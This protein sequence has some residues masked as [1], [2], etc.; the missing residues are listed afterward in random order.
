MR[1]F[2][3]AVAAF[4]ALFFNLA[5][6]DIAAAQQ[7]AE[8][9]IAIPNRSPGRLACRNMQ[10]LEEAIAALPTAQSAERNSDGLKGEGCFWVAGTGLLPVSGPIG[11]RYAG[12]YL[13]LVTVVNLA[14]GTGLL[15]PAVIADKRKWRL[16]DECA[17]LD[18]F[19]SARILATGEKHMFFGQRRK[20]FDPFCV[21]L[22][23][24]VA[25]ADA[26][27]QPQQYLSDNWQTRSYWRNMI[28]CQD[29]GGL[30]QSLD[31]MV[32]EQQINNSDSAT[33]TMKN[34]CIFRA[35]DEIVASRFL[36]LYTTMPV[37]AKGPQ[38]VV[39][40]HEVVHINRRTGVLTTA[41]MPTTP[42]RARMLR[43]PAECASPMPI[44]V[45]GRRVVYLSGAEQGS[46]EAAVVDTP[47]GRKVAYSDLPEVIGVQSCTKQD[48]VFQR[49]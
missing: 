24:R 11:W 23:D 33:F 22:V 26:L 7:A 1:F 14:D 41:L 30:T 35:E 36:G 21:N 10:A 25:E 47:T 6:A 13:F 34:G 46:V 48:L 37:S 27:N 32:N 38:F 19:A 39:E 20:G 8:A 2:R 42:V 3:L 43:L 5:A 49:R 31:R 9:A 16:E 45:R 29:L 17:E 18:V 40:I 15:H 28:A 4:F 44:P 12:D